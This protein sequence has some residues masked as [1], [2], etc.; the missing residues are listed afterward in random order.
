LQYQISYAHGNPY[1][2]LL[3]TEVQALIEEMHGSRYVEEQKLNHQLQ[4]INREINS[5]KRKLSSLEKQRVEI[6]RL[7][8]R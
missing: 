4:T 5:L 2:K 3:R 7:Q 8:N 1:Y 6:T